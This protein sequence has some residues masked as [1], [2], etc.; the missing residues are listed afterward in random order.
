M[1]EIKSPSFISENA[2]NIARLRN[3]HSPS[4]SS[5]LH[6][7]PTYASLAFTVPHQ[8]RHQGSPPTAPGAWIQAR[9]GWADL[10][11]PDDDGLQTKASL[12]PP[13]AHATPAS[14]LTHTLGSAQ[15]KILPFKN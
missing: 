12:V 15:W 1:D 11:T 10:V 8:S 13:L 5:S 2:P 4:S 7:H 14:Q 6:L 3:A 9:E